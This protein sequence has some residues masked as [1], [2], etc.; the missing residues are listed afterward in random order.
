MSRA[1]KRPPH[2]IERDDAMKAQGCLSIP[3]AAKALGVSA[4]RAYAL[5]SAGALAVQKLGGSVYVSA[6]SLKA[7]QDAQKAPPGWIQLSTACHL[8]HYHK[9]TLNKRA[10]VGQLRRQRFGGRTYFAV[11]DLEAMVRVSTA[12]DAP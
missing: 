10:A 12:L 2:R 3:V 7:Y 8:Y 11:A 4:A 1:H 9:A 6:A 5:A